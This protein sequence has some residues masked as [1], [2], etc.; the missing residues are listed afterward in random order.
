MCEEH[1]AGV[2]CE[3]EKY[4]KIMSVMRQNEKLKKENN[5]LKKRIT[6]LEIEKSYMINPNALGNRNNEM[7]W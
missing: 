3:H 6:E 1:S 5:A 2:K 7:G 4:C